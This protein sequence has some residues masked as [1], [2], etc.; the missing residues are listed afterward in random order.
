LNTKA[1]FSS[2]IYSEQVTITL[3]DDG[4]THSRRQRRDADTFPQILQFNLTSNTKHI[5]LFLRRNSL[6]AAVPYYTQE[7][8]EIVKH[9][10]ASEKVSK[11]I[12]KI[13]STKEKHYFLLID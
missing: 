2:F 12:F 13:A 3:I 1:T 11:Y 6:K 10:P 7:Y 9:T 8:D 4:S 5:K